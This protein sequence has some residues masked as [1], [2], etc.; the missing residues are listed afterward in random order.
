MPGFMLASELMKFRAM[1]LGLAKLAAATAVTGGLA[2]CA[3]THGKIVV[4]S[5]ALPYQAPD[6]SEITGID[7]D[8]T[9]D[10]ASDAGSAAGSAA[11]K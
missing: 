7:E 9:G 8:D 2:G 11:A 10:S 6:I 4:D 1:I 3:G 5:P